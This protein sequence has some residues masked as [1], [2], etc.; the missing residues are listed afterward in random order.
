MLYLSRLLDNNFS[1]ICSYNKYLYVFVCL[2]FKILKIWIFCK[3]TN[4]NLFVLS[5]GFCARKQA[6]KYKSQLFIEIG[7]GSIDLWFSNLIWKLWILVFI[8]PN[9][10]EQNENLYT[11]LYN[12]FYFFLEFILIIRTEKNSFFIFVFK[13]FS[14]LN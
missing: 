11:S 8:K 12:N 14:C 6:R 5:K 9:K 7:N 2:F 10:A 13:Y 4:E 1:Q 3:I